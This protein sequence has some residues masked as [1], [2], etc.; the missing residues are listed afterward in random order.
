[1]IIRYKMK[2]IHDHFDFKTF[3]SNCHSCKKN[4][5]TREFRT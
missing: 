5:H 3:I 1:M 2:Q 4:T